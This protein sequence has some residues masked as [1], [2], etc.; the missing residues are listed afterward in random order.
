[1]KSVPSAKAVRIGN[2]QGF[3]GDNVDA[4]VR[5]A[6]DGGLHYLTLEYLAELTMAILFKSRLKKP[7]SAA[8]T[9]AGSTCPGY[10]WTVGCTPPQ[11][12]SIAASAISS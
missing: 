3:W 2:G 7:G 6:R 12:I 10:S 5:L 11:V 9:L 8:P 1:M 4:P